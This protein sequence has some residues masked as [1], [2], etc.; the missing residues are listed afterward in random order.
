M[1][2]VRFLTQIFEER[3]RQNDSNRDKH[4]QVV[5]IQ[6][7]FTAKRLNR[8]Q[9]LYTSHVEHKKVQRLTQSFPLGPGMLGSLQAA[10]I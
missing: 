8:G 4:H 3:Q 1:I 7:P 9:S 6:V 2:S 10:R 5:P